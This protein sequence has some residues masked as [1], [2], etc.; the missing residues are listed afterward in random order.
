MQ[1]RWWGCEM[2]FEPLFEALWEP[3][4]NAGKIIAMCAVQDQIMIACEYRIFRCWSDPYTGMWKSHEVTP[5]NPEPKPCDLSAAYSPGEP[6]P[7]VWSVLWEWVRGWF[8]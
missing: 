3:P 6:Y 4:V 1:A 8:K 2:S 5:A 7:T